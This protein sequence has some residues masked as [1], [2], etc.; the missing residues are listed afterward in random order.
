MAG[1]WLV[2]LREVLSVNRTGRVTGSKTPVV[3]ASATPVA[4]RLQIAL[5]PAGECPPTGADEIE[6]TG[7]TA[8]SP[9][10]AGVGAPRGHCS[11]A[12]NT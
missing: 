6:T 1:T 5:P 7:T 4:S 2:S 12:T 9:F 11:T 10:V 8:V 3:V